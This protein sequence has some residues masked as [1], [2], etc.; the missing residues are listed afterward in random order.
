MS[1]AWARPNPWRDAVARGMT[2]ASSPGSLIFLNAV[3]GV[4]A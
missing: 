4:L 3:R 2:I 1:L